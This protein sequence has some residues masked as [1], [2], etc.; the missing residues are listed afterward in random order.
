[1]SSSLSHA[2]S[3]SRT[4]IAY[5]ALFSVAVLYTFKCSLR[6]IVLVTLMFA[7]SLTAFF[8]LI[9]KN[10][11]VIEARL[12]PMKIKEM[13]SW[14][15]IF[16]AIFLISYVMIFWL[17]SKEGVTIASWWSLP[18][19]AASL[20]VGFCISVEAMAVNKFFE[21]TVRIQND[22]K[23]EVIDTGLY[24]IVRHPG[25]VGFALVFTG[26]AL[27][28][29]SWHALCA[30]CLTIFALFARTEAEDRMLKKHLQGY[31]N[32]TT[33]VTKKLIPGV[34]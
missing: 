25:Y 33:R 15:V 22:R 23:H 9:K 8:Y 17:A 21:K 31:A 28:I 19:G 20:I 26:T 1:M 29:G 34:W 13:Q 14:D 10:P 24:A 5:H 2:A 4:L 11:A 16:L 3:A 12:R 6:S 32:Y 7:S 18:F 30:S 27:I